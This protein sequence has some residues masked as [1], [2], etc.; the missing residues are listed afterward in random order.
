MNKQLQ[1]SILILVATALLGTFYPKGTAIM[2]D[3]AVRVGMA[4]TLLFAFLS[5]RVKPKSELS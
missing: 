2:T 4:L 1:I 3:I 5:L